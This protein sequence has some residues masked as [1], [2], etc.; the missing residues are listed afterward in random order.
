M[1]ARVGVGGGP[2]IHLGIPII[3][4]IVMLTVSIVMYSKTGNAAVLVGPCIV[5]VI[6]IL[7][8]INFYI[9][10]RKLAQALD[11]AACDS[12]NAGAAGAVYYD[13]STA[14]YATANV[15]YPTGTTQP[16]PA[17]QPYPYAHAPPSYQPPGAEPYNQASAAYQQNPAVTPYAPNVSTQA[18]QQ[19]Y[20]PSLAPRPSGTPSV[21]INPSA[22]IPTNPGEASAPRIS[23]QAPAPYNPSMPYNA[24]P[25]I[26]YNPATAQYPP[27]AQAYDAPPPSY[28]E[29]R[30]I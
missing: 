28:E 30:K 25:Y 23:A 11:Q 24:A 20:D 12:L 26:P 1:P 13:P 18:M 4:A 9:R 29:S 19:P 5:V 15:A 10:R 27:Q 21:H 7:V 14:Q 2:L 6:F 22:Q 17:G 3:I 16:Y 8:S